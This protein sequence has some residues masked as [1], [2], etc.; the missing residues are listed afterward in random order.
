VG[1]LVGI[2]VGCIGIGGVL[3]VPALTYIGGMDIHVAIASCMLAYLFS[4]LM[5]AVAFARRGSIRWSMA[6]WLCAGA[7][8]G[9][10]LGAAGVSL[11]PALALELLIAGL[12]LFAGV[13]AL[14]SGAGG[15][16]AERR[17]GPLPLVLIGMVTGF[18]SAMSGTGGPLILVP[19]LVWLEL[20]ILTAVGLSQVIQLPVAALATAG[21]L[22]Y[23]RIDLAVALGVAVLL[24]AGVAVGAR[25]AHRVS[26]DALKRTVAM[27][28]M[29]VGML[30]AGRIAFVDLLH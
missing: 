1:L 3:L 29:G 23:G 18:G 2:L 5:G 4:G 8:P 27:A 16:G 22:T 17:L 19:L 25:I 21:N 24:V 13:H 11:L 26:A 28:L 30:I 10:Y 12:I 9:A 7:M 6:G 20:P 15:A 14:A